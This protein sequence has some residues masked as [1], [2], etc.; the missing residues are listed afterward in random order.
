VRWRPR[1]YPKVL[2][3]L[4]VVPPAAWVSF[5]AMC[6]ALGPLVSVAL[7]APASLVSLSLSGWTIHRG[8]RRYRRGKWV[9]W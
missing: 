4:R 5:T 8:V 7:A 1:R 6:V 3:Y 2:W 9:A